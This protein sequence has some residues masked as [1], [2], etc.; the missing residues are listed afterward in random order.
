M[1]PL[2]WQ[3]IPEALFRTSIWKD[4]NDVSVPLDAALLEN[5][6]DAKQQNE[7]LAVQEVKGKQILRFLTKAHV[8][9]VMMSQIKI[10]VEQLCEA[11]RTM[12]IMALDCISSALLADIISRFCSEKV[13]RAA[14]VP[15]GF[16]KSGNRESCVTD[17]V[18]RCGQ[19][20]EGH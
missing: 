12:S 1:R 17:A 14:R 10:S 7:V 20:C 16:E 3:K 2:H 9:G 11:I 8:V 13:S 4:L 5:L 6:F 19:N 18:R 15:C